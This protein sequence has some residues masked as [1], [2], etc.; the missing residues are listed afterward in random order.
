VLSAKNQNKD[1]K[2]EMKSSVQLLNVCIVAGFL[3]KENHDCLLTK[4][5]QSQHGLEVV[6]ESESRLNCYYGAHPSGVQ[7]FVKQNE[8]FC[9]NLLL[10]SDGRGLATTIS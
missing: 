2:L 7:T 4:F 8:N 5:Q 3:I 6:Y 10:S 9:S 1:M